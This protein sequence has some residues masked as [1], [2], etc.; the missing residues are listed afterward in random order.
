MLTF[1]EASKSLYSMP[2]YHA[3]SSG[4]YFIVVLCT[5]VHTI[6]WFLQSDLQAVMK[7][8]VMGFIFNGKS[9]Y[10]R[11]PWNVLDIAVVAVS[12]IVL[13]VESIMDA[14]NLVW[15]RALRALRFVWRW[16]NWPY[17]DE[18]YEN[19]TSYTTQHDAYN[20]G[21]S[22]LR[23]IYISKCILQTHPLFYRMCQWL[24]QKDSCMAL[25]AFTE[26]ML[27]C[28]NYLII[29]VILGCT[30]RALRPLRA[31]SR[32]QGIKVVVTAV[33]AAIPAMGDVLLVGLLFYFIF[34]VLAVN[35]L[36]GKMFYCTDEQ[37]NVLDPYYLVQAGDNINKTWWDDAQCISV[38]V[39][40]LLMWCMDS[41]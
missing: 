33:L 14:R 26:L 10:M 22:I 38:Y 19:H 21:I 9:S 17:C 20:T 23:S 35:L 24:M 30:C 2:W 41:V 8:I 4:M 12:V 11:S 6:S 5:C 15:L 39:E 40:Y 18:G 25:I 31:A 28:Y 13:I 32:L 27:T 7:V 29:T 1:C 3:W 36:I 34:A 37:G 16:W